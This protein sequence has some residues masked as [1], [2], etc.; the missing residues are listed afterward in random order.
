MMY[1]IRS[2]IRYLCGKNLEK[3]QF[4]CFLKINKNIFDQFAQFSGD[5]FMQNGNQI[6][7]ELQRLR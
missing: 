4:N 2:K 6:A 5:L 7:K 3:D 1:A